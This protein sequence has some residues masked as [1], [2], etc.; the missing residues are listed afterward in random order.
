MIINAEAKLNIKGLSTNTL[1]TCQSRSID[2]NEIKHNDD[3]IF[4]YT[5]STFSTNIKTISV[6]FNTLNRLSYDKMIT[7]KTST[8]KEL[9]L[10]N[11]DIFENTNTVNIIKNMLD[12]KTYNNKPLYLAINTNKYHI[13]Y[14]IINCKDSYY[15][16]LNIFPNSLLLQLDEENDIITFDIKKLKNFLLLLEYQLHVR[17][18]YEKN[19]HNE[20]YYIIHKKLFDKILFGRERI[21]IN[22]KVYNKA[23]ITYLSGPTVS[24]PDIDI[25]FIKN[26]MNIDE[27]P[28]DIRTWSLIIQY[29]N[30]NGYKY[31]IFSIKSYLY[32]VGTFLPQLLSNILGVVLLYK[33]TKD[34]IELFNAKEFR[35]II[36]DFEFNI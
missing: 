21:S 36:L 28:F 12:T 17:H 29:L 4:E 24:T 2:Y 14:P 32:K 23:L 27:D 20:N 31:N 5:I 22:E 1:Q 30:A 19:K 8:L 35:D 34:K 3:I 6:L 7:D 16:N 33:G 25:E 13:A 15:L 26:T 9:I 18:I 11:K 10:N